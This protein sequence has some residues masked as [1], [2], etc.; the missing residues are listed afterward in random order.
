MR[1]Y[2]FSF[3][4]GLLALFGHQPVAADGSKWAQHDPGA[5][6]A[7]D[8]SL[9]GQIL[10]QAIVPYEEIKEQVSRSKWDC[11]HTRSRIPTCNTS[12]YGNENMKGVNIV[13]YKYFKEE[14][15]L[16]IRSYLRKMSRIPIHHYNRKEQLAFWLNVRNAAVMHVI[17]EEYPVG[18]LE[19][20]RPDPGERPG[21]DSPWARAVLEVDGVSLSITDIEQEVLL[22]N[23]KDPVLLYG[24]Y[25]GS[26]GGPTLMKEPF[27]GWRVYRQLRRNGYAY[28]NSR[29][30]MRI[31]GDELNLSHV[32]AFG[33]PLFENTPA[34]LA[35]LHDLAA[36][37]L[38]ELLG[39]IDDIEFD[40]EDFKIAE[41]NPTDDFQD[42]A[43]ANR[44]ID[45]NGTI[46]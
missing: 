3:L 1:R 9:W 29:R 20:L 15:D 37:S 18:S 32:F 45:W 25:D 8:H 19:D 36:P 6:E 35:H 30:S 12:S 43:L 33:R 41:Y 27:E 46:Q 44:Y 24:L 5:W 39:G 26:V 23:W 21:K 14:F 42:R 7:I 40:Y 38:Q 16:F 31:F 13:P 4:A 28:I 10:E 34:L 22:A 17:Y 2:V 11:K